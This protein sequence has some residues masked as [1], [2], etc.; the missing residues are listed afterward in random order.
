MK[1]EILLNSGSG[2]IGI[3]ILAA[4]QTTIVHA[5]INACHAAALFPLILILGQC[6]GL[7][8][9]SFQKFAVDAMPMPDAKPG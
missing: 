7:A 9:N 3:A 8:Y 4:I 5:D 1:L 6:Q 2:V